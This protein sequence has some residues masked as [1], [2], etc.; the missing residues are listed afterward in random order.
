M[1]H[2]DLELSIIDDLRQILHK[3]GDTSHTQRLNRHT[4][5]DHTYSTNQDSRE[6]EAND[7]PYT[8]RLRHVPRSINL[9]EIQNHL[10]Y[11]DNVTD[12][13]EVE[14]LPHSLR[15]VLCTFDSSANHRLLAHI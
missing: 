8:Y 14:N 6:E 1:S 3:A 12:V 11:Y 9:N 4:Q 15:E 10:S 5:I 13:Q 2:P 7:M